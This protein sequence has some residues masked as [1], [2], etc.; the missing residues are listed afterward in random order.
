MTSL[1]E[2]PKPSKAT[3]KVCVHRDCCGRG[4]ERL[5]ERLHRECSAEAEVRKTDECFRFCK[6][7]PNVAVNGNVLHHMNERNVVSRVRSELRTPS[8]KTDG[9]GTRKMEDLDDVLDD[10]FRL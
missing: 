3:I 9:V 2:S 4:S 8:T 6:S 5:Y 10:L 7:G 1:A